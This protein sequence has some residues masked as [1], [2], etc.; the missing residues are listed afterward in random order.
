M[1]L[2]TVYFNPATIM[3]H[4][5]L[6]YSYIFVYD[7]YYYFSVIILVDTYPKRSRSLGVILTFNTIKT[8]CLV[9]LCGV[10]RLL[11]KEIFHHNLFSPNYLL[12][13]NVAIGF[14]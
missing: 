13:A 9:S 6:F 14:G 2:L 5:S 4:P 8:L 3:Y 7:Y 11:L 12:K 1:Y 10:I